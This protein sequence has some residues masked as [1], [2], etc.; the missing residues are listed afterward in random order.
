MSV[1]RVKKSSEKSFWVS[2]LFNRSVVYAAM[3]DGSRNSQSMHTLA[4]RLAVSVGYRTD[5]LSTGFM[6]VYNPQDTSTAW[7]ELLGW[8]VTI[9]EMET[10]L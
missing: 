2:A 9:G 6:P 1:Q 4:E 3:V 7:P 8:L 5:R 10:V